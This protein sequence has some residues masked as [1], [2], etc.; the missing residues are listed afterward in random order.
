MF[1]VYDRRPMSL[2]VHYLRNLSDPESECWK[3]NSLR[4]DLVGALAVAL[5][6]FK[7]FPDAAGFRIVD[8]EGEIITE[9]TRALS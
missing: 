8:D 4:A 9:E 7:H 1:P 3:L 5:E 2:M 6:G